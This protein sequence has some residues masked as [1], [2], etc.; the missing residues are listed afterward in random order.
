M[1]ELTWLARVEFCVSRMGDHGNGSMNS[2]SF[3]IRSENRKL[4]VS[5]HLMRGYTMP[6]VGIARNGAL[7]QERI[8]NSSLAPPSIAV[9]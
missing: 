6:S 5:W 3:T 8:H 7:L 1:W 2:V 9:R 4:L